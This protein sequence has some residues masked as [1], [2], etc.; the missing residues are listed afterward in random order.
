MKK[1]VQQAH[2]TQEV[3]PQYREEQY[4][5]SANNSHSDHSRG[6]SVREIR[7]SFEARAEE[8]SVLRNG[9]SSHYCRS[10]SVNSRNSDSVGAC[11]ACAKTKVSDIVVGNGT[12]PIGSSVSCSDTVFIDED[13]GCQQHKPNGSAEI[14]CRTLADPESAQDR[15]VKSRSYIEQL[16]QNLAT[17]LRTETVKT[18]RHEY[19]PNL[20]P[21]STSKAGRPQLID[22]NRNEKGSHD[23]RKA[24][25]PSSLSNGKQESSGNNRQTLLRKE[26]VEKGDRSV[27]GLKRRKLPLLGIIFGPADTSPTRKLADTHKKHTSN[28]DETTDSG[29]FLNVVGH[30]VEDDSAQLGS[31]FG[32]QYS[33]D[34]S[35]TVTSQSCLKREVKLGDTV[36]GETT[37]KESDRTVHSNESSSLSA[38]IDVN[39]PNCG[40]LSDESQ[41]QTNSA[42]KSVV[43]VPPPKPARVSWTTRLIEKLTEEEEKRKIRSQTRVQ[44]PKRIVGFPQKKVKG[45]NQYKAKSS[46]GSKNESAAPVVLQPK[47]EVSAK[48]SDT[49]SDSGKKEIKESPSG[50][51]VDESSKDGYASLLYQ[52]TDSKKEEDQNVPESSG[53]DLLLKQKR[54]EE[55]RAAVAR[56]E[57]ASTSSDDDSVFSVAITASTGSIEAGRRKEP[58]PSGIRRLLPQGLFVQRH[59]HLG[60][61]DET[62]VHERLLKRSDA[63]RVYPA[64]N[65]ARPVLETAFLSDTSSKLPVRSAVRQ[66]QRAQ[67][68]SPAS[69]HKQAS[70]R[71]RRRQKDVDQKIIQENEQN[72]TRFSNQARSKSLSPARDRRSPATN[73]TSKRTIPDTSLVLEE[74]LE[75]IRRE[76]SPPPGRDVRRPSSTPPSVYHKRVSQLQDSPTSSS[77]KILHQERIFHYPIAVYGDTPDGAYFHSPPSRR[78]QQNKDP[79]TDHKTD[80]NQRK[81]SGGSSASSTSTIVAESPPVTA[82]SWNPLLLNLENQ[83]LSGSPDIR[84][85][86]QQR[87]PYTSNHGGL[88][89]GDI[90]RDTRTVTPDIY[91]HPNSGL[92]RGP[93]RLPEVHRDTSVVQVN[94]PTSVPSGRLSA[95]PVPSYYIEDYQ[96]RRVLSP[97]PRRTQQDYE[98]VQLSGRSSSHPPRLRQSNQTS[99]ANPAHQ[100]AVPTDKRLVAPVPVQLHVTSQPRQREERNAN[101]KETQTASSYMQQQYRQVMEGLRSDSRPQYKKL[102]RHEVEALYWETQKLREGLSSLHLHIS[103]APRLADSSGSTVLLPQSPPHGVVR[104]EQ[105][106]PMLFQPEAISR[107]PFRTQSVQNVGSGYGS[108]IV[109]PQ[110]IYNIAQLMQLS[111]TSNDPNVKASRARSASPGPNSNR[112]LSSRSLSLPR[113]SA[114]PMMVEGLP[115]KAS[116][117]TVD[118][119]KRGVLQRNTIGP[120]RTASHSPQVRKLATPTIYEELPQQ[121]T[122]AVYADR[123]KHDSKADGGYG[124]RTSKVPSSKSQNSVVSMLNRSPLSVDAN[125]AKKSVSNKKNKKPLPEGTVSHQHYYPP[126]FKRGSL[127]SASTSSFDGVDSLVSPKRVSFTNSYTDEPRNWPTRNGPAPEPP[128]RQR[129]IHR[130]D[131]DVFVPDDENSYAAV[132]EAPNRP[133]PPVP[134]DL[135]R[136]MYGMIAR[137]CNDTKSS[138]ASAVPVPVHRWQQQSESES[139]SEAGEVQRILQQGSHGRGTYFRFTGKTSVITPEGRNQCGGFVAGINGGEFLCVCV[140]KF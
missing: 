35:A 54:L 4:G 140:C 16:Q 28:R 118:Y 132:P 20:G 100:P 1:V 48:V 88:H 126:I 39:N 78:R 89:Y 6:Y 25:G 106:S 121:V 34:L 127:V 49:S 139:G 33:D 133:L 74:R 105:N 138:P 11:G 15:L 128:T 108:V 95:P 57:C 22:S 3:T 80:E 36:S 120:I 59:R 60:G 79:E 69:R 135:D 14:L 85:L 46:E 123:H 71:S 109:R 114:A 122:R 107:R 93:Q 84:K 8:G 70:P 62:A 32:S 129:K 115:H 52:L 81:V 10:D 38:L 134:R 87:Y 77:N 37:D 19:S 30:S 42:P 98:D 2:E 26:S 116:D 68:S 99:S 96:R 136:G 24:V 130:L 101:S 29:Q 90:H 63:V 97:E 102:T 82:T 23:S 117:D 111:R 67:S 92:A 9:S 104:S 76:L 86:Q 7:K 75:H 47:A 103:H 21:R 50:V 53:E 61:T 65:A 40:K 55:L 119:F 27:P 64:T 18:F 131:S 41:Q 56:E 137:K 45:C 31:G 94:S 5:Y 51:V 125:D 72:S 112:H 73:T 124:N 113:S 12:L 44:K 58:K 83:A 17:K 43:A 66:Q 91:Y 13:V 110:P